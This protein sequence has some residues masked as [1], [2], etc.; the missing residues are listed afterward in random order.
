MYFFI[1]VLIFMVMNFFPDSVSWTIH[2]RF[3]LKDESN[4]PAWFSSMLLLLVSIGSLTLHFLQDKTAKTSRFWLFMSGVYLYLSADEGAMLHEA[5]SPHVKWF[6]V[7]APLSGL[8]FLYVVRHCLRYESTQI[9]NRI[10]GGM[11]LFA[12]G[13]LFFEVLWYYNRPVSDQAYHILAVFQ[14]GCEMIGSITVLSGVLMRLNMQF[15]GEVTAS[16]G[17]SHERLD[18][19]RGTLLGRLLLWM[20]GVR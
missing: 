1:A 7:Y 15:N 12:G 17:Q 10:I 13:S 18:A 3:D 2:Q 14:E 8:F 11:L 5:L 19:Y 20:L 6:Y 9:R 4:L 16:S